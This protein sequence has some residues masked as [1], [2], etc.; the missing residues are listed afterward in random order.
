MQEDNEADDAV[1]GC[2]KNGGH[3]AEL[4]GSRGISDLVFGEALQASDEEEAD[5][6][7]DEGYD[8][9]SDDPGK[10][11]AN[12]IYDVVVPVELE[13]VK[14]TFILRRH[15]LK[16]HYYGISLSL[17]AFSGRMDA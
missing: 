14:Q 4:P 9:D 11:R 3:R 6:L 10:V 1:A 13:S 5:A 16:E 12:E 15:R 17:R 8:K 2:A 7:E